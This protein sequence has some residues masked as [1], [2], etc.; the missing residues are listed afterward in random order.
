M[1]HDFLSVKLITIKWKEG[2]TTEGNTSYSSLY[3][4]MLKVTKA[5]HKGNVLL[6]PSDL[7][8]STCIKIC[9]EPASDLRIHSSKLCVKAECLCISSPFF[10]GGIQIL[11]AYY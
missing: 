1:R 2:K 9:Y 5:K 6:L 8:P 7:M 10:Y 3:Q 11:C 4:H